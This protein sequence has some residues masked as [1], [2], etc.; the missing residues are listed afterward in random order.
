MKLTP[1]L[2]RRAD[3][4]KPGDRGARIYLDPRGI[5]HKT[6][7]AGNFVSAVI[8]HAEERKKSIAE[9]LYLVERLRNLGAVHRL[10]QVDAQGAVFQSFRGTG[11]RQGCHTMPCQLVLDRQ[12]P[13]QLRP[14]DGAKFSVRYLERAIKLFAR[15]TWSPKIVNPIDQALDW[16]PEANFVKVYTDSVKAV[17]SGIAPEDAYREASWRRSRV[18]QDL[19]DRVRDEPLNTYDAMLLIGALTP[20]TDEQL[21]KAE[22]ERLLSDAQYISALQDQRET[23]IEV[24]A[25]REQ[26]TPVILES[27]QLKQE[28]TSEQWLGAKNPQSETAKASEN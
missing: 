12:F 13:H 24:Y 21:N 23:V 9:S 20:P 15:C 18:L 19:R 14:S 7:P 22:I 28:V 8:N 25:A 5:H 4:L 6:V 11:E 16:T 26:T 1:S 2:L 10:T 3:Q 27:G 17:L